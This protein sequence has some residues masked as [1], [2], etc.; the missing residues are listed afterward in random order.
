MPLEA[1][2]ILGVACHFSRPGMEVVGT[3]FRLVFV[4][5]RGILSP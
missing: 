1:D 3:L 2:E 5:A 4:D